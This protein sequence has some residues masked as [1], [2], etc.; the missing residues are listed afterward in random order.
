MADQSQYL[1]AALQ[2]LKGDAEPSQPMVPQLAQQY[3]QAARARQQQATLQGLGTD[4]SLLPPTVDPNGIP[5]VSAGAP[6]PQS[7]QSQPFNPAEGP[8]GGLY[9]L[10]QKL[11]GLFSGG[12]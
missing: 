5:G 8:F 12:N 6:M 10:G 2:A 7:S 11:K 1:L 4:Q 3:A 9:G